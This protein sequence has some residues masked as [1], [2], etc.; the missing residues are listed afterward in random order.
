[1]ELPPEHRLG[2]YEMLLVNTRE[3][4]ED[5]LVKEQE[6]EPDIFRLHPTILRASKQIHSEARPVLY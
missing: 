1:M 4:D 3:K 6:E 5:G 2:V